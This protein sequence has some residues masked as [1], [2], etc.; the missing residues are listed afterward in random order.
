MNFHFIKI[1]FI[2]FLSLFLVSC[3]NSKS[4]RV[5]P[6]TTSHYNQQRIFSKQC[7]TGS[8]QIYR[9]ASRQTGVTGGVYTQPL[10]GSAHPASL[11]PGAKVTIQGTA[12]NGSPCY[13]G[14]VSFSCSARVVTQGIS[15]F[16]ESGTIGPGTY[17][18]TTS[19]IHALTTT[20]AYQPTI[21]HQTT[22]GYHTTIGAHHTT[23]GTLYPTRSEIINGE[24]RIISSGLKAYASISFRNPSVPNF[25]CNVRLDLDCP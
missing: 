23:A 13:Q 12:M 22:V 8:F 11:N 24:F 6:G 21:G 20:G 3:G 25:L 10:T 1:V 16:C 7:N 5:I 4:G 17:Y 18:P 19:G 2:V 14:Q 9:Q 15:F